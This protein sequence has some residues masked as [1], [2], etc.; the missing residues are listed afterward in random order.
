MKIKR[1][2][3]KGFFLLGSG[4]ILSA[5]TRPIHV[6]IVDKPIDVPLEQ[7]AQQYAFVGYP[8]DFIYT[9][10]VAPGARPTPISY[11]ISSEGPAASVN[12]CATSVYNAIGQHVPSQ[13]TWSGTAYGYFNNNAFLIVSN[14]GPGAIITVRATFQLGINR[15]QGSD[16]VTY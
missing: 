8:P 11:E 10:N 12:T 6:N 9:G 2:L 1:W 5:C 4:L 13:Y 15:Y 16:T 3:L 14:C 7:N